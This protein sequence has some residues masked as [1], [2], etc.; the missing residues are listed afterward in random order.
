MENCFHLQGKKNNFKN[1]CKPTFKGDGYTYV[2]YSQT[3]NYTCMLGNEK[4]TNQLSLPMARH[5]GHR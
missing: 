2:E 3:F 4:N 5:A 1:V